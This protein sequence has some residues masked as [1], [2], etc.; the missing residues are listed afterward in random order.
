MNSAVLFRRPVLVCVAAV[1]L[2]LSAALSLDALRVIQSSDAELL[3]A[4]EGAAYEDVF[5]FGFWPFWVPVALLQV[6]A[7]VSVYRVAR[8]NSLRHLGSAMLAAF[9]VAW[10]LSYATYSREH[11]L[12]QTFVEQKR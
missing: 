7:A 8:A 2:V 4:F 5:G 1:G 11:A 6:I 12:W 10:V 9:V 3:K